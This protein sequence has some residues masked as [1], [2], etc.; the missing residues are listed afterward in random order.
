MMSNNKILIQSYSTV[1]LLVLTTFLAT[2]FFLKVSYGIE[3]TTLS[4][5]ALF[6]ICTSLW[7]VWII[8]IISNIARSRFKQQAWYFPFLIVFAKWPIDWGYDQLIELGAL[9]QIWLSLYCPLLW[10]CVAHLSLTFC[11]KRSPI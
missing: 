11:F 10:T 6:L 3:L 4:E 8:S 1:F 2:K 5:E 7:L 9:N